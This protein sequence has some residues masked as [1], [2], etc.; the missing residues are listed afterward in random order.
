MAN[1]HLIKLQL[2]QQQ[3]QIKKQLI[4]KMLFEIGK[5]KLLEI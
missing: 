1:K 4:K 5:V 3:R 2:V